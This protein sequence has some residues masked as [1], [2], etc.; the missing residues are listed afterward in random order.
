MEEEGNAHFLIVEGVVSYSTCSL[1]NRAIFHDRLFLELMEKNSFCC[2]SYFLQE[3]KLLQGRTVLLNVITPSLAAGCI[4]SSLCLF[5]RL[6]RGCWRTLGGSILER[7]QRVFT[8]VDQCH[9]WTLG[10][11]LQAF[12]RPHGGE[13]LTISPTEALRLPPYSSWCLQSPGAHLLR[14]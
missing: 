7:G 14:K 3:Y 12:S 9:S 10:G 8:P 11:Y 6:R 2:D 13:S 4:T 1:W 5:L